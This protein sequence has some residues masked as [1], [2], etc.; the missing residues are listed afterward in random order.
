MLVL[1]WPAL[2]ALLRQARVLAELESNR[3]GRDTSY[4]QV[5]SSSSLYR[6]LLIV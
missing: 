5:L 2:L 1:P 6:T 4:Q 3:C